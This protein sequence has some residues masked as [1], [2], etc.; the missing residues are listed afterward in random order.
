MGV[1]IATACS[2][3]VQRLLASVVLVGLGGELT[4][5]LLPSRLLIPNQCVRT[6]HSD[7]RRC[8]VW[9]SR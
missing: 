6:V 5:A 2:C 9:L 4:G 1:S 7:Q 3:R 8:S